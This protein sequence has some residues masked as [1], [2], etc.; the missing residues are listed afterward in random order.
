MMGGFKPVDELTQE[1]IWVV[2]CRY[3]RLTTC[4]MAERCRASQATAAR[5]IRAGKMMTHRR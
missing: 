4:E 1:N 5:V 3:G 2:H